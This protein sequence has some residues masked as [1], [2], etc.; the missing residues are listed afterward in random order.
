MGEDAAPNPLGLR[1]WF[2]RMVRCCLHVSSSGPTKRLGDIVNYN[3]SSQASFFLGGDPREAPAAANRLDFSYLVDGGRH[4]RGDSP[5]KEEFLF[6]LDSSPSSSER[7][8]L[9]RTMRLICARA[10]RRYAV[11]LLGVLLETFV[12]ACTHLPV[13]RKDAADVRAAEK[14]TSFWTFDAGG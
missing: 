7:N 3:T 4:D 1:A 13:G 11:I 10:H 5:L 9:H 6:A 8:S 14:P 12:A 2:P